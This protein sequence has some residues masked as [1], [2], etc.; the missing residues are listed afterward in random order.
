MCCLAAV[1]QRRTP[2]TGRDRYWL[3]MGHASSGCV[4]GQRKMKRSGNEGGNC[5]LEMMKRKTGE[6]P[7]NMSEGKEIGD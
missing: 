6:A 3:C 5:K 4:A 7:W 2:R 1:Q